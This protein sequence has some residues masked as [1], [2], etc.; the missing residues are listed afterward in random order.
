MAD[1]ELTT[2]SWDN[3][4]W[5]PVWQES[6]EFAA[7]WSSSRTAA[8]NLLR[9]SAGLIWAAAVLAPITVYVTHG[10]ARSLLISAEIMLGFGAAIVAV[11]ALSWNISARRAFDE[12]LQSVTAAATR[13]A[14]SK[15][16]RADEI[17]LKDLFVINRRQLDEYHTTSM[18]E[19]HSAFRNTQLSAAIGFTFLLIGVVISFS[20]GS[21][22]ADG[23]TYASAGL[24]A[25][26]AT[27]SGFLS[28]TFFRSYRATTKALRNY[29][30]EPVRTGQVLST[31]RVAALDRDP[32]TSAKLREKIVE[33]LISQIPMNAPNQDGVAQMNGESE[34]EKSE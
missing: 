25:L 16:G 10:T 13:E 14:V 20:L 5:V 9:A 21:K 29:Y 32:A 12:K 30:W 7:W 19:Q 8:K 1:H 34:K 27:L 4:E 2:G 15:L 28:H 11:I 31:E 6:P 17:K 24:T 18:Q 33:K 26:G 3:P 23:A 22:Q